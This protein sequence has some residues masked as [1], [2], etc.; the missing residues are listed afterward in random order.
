[1]LQGSN[2][3]QRGLNYASHLERAFEGYRARVSIGAFGHN[4]SGM[5]FDAAFQQAAFAL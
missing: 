4:C 1:M 2:R 3:L 5:F